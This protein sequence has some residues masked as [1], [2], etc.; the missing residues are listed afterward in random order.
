MGYWLSQVLW[1][2]V[3]EIFVAAIMG[4]AVMIWGRWE[5][6]KRW[7]AVIGGIVVMAAIFLIL[8]QSG[9]WEPPVKVKI[10]QWL[11]DLSFSIKDVP[12]AGGSNVDFQFEVTV[13]FV[14]GA[15]P[16][17][18]K[19]IFSIYRPA[20]VGHEFIIMEFGYDMAGSF[21]KLNHIEAQETHQL[22]RQIG[23]D[24]AMKGVSYT[25]EDGGRIKLAYA[26]A[27]SSIT[28]EQLL[29]GYENLVNG[30]VIVTQDIGLALKV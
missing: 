25:F 10:H 6:S 29:R 11:D 24:L 22:N 16:A 2:V 21:P 18:P 5:G 9:W 12:P 27:A 17:V 19:L 7:N 3:G 15:E 23:K 30:I 26:I 20:H 8:N 14:V 13:D 1:S 4:A 28:Q